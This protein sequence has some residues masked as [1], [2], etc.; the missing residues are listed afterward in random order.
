MSLLANL[1]AFI[2]TTFLLAMVPGQGVAMVMRQTILGGTK[3]AILSVLGN[4]TG[5][6]I[7]GFASSIGLSAIFRDSPTAYAILKWC[8]VAFLAYLA[9]QTAFQ[10]R[11]EQGKF[12]VDETQARPVNNSPFAA[13][14]VGLFTNLTN[15]KA[16]VFAV[17]FLPVYVPKDLAIGAGIAILGFVWAAVSTSWYLLLIGSMSKAQVWLQRPRVRR[18]LT[19]ASAVGL[20]CLAVAL[21]I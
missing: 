6:I 13:Y 2:A 19:A 3:T 10:L 9:I 14:R 16:A 17:A 11:K 8:G 4:S 15:V 18:G 20:A 1:P 12:G 7:W 21:A 5:L